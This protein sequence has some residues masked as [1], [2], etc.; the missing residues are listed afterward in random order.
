MLGILQHMTEIYIYTL[1]SVLIVSL[2]SLVG[3]VA[4]SF[5]KRILNSIVPI[6]VSVAVGAMLG[7]AFIHLIPEAFESGMEG[8]TVSLLIIGGM[9]LFFVLEKF[10]HWHHSHGE[11]DVDEYCECDHKDEEGN[12]RPLGYLV[13]FSD[14]FHNFIDG[15]IIAASFLISIPVGIATTIAVLLHE[16][17][18]ELGDFGVLLH[19]G[20]SKTRAL[21][22]NFLSAIL[23]FLG[24]GVVFILGGL[25]DN[26]VQ[27]IIPIA[28]GSFVYIATADLIPELHKTTE[29]KKSLI[30]FGA[31]LFGIA[32]MVM[33][34]FL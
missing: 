11:N 17:P 21:F 28:A 30:Q 24:A 27:W 5:S 33:L 9:L 34:I 32:L 16:I 15:M 18:Q 4:L 8:I 1:V 20:F 3:I 23:A 19:A 26:I 2:T 7:D 31:F 13:L 10:L 6:L 25:V 29:F 12:V 14:G 22:V